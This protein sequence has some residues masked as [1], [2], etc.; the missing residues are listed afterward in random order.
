MI[1]RYSLLPTETLFIDDNQKNG[2]T[3]N[4]LGIISK[5]V[6]TDNYQSVID[7]ANEMN[8]I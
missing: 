7:L 3:G 8:L 5:K 6:E 1:N 2:D 4:E